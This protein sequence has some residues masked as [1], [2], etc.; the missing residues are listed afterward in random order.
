MTGEE[1]G[2]WIQGASVVVAVGASVV[3]LVVGAVDRR[4]AKGNAEKDREAARS[5][6]AEERLAAAQHARRVADFEALLRLAENQRRGGS[7][8]G[9]TR[10]ALGAEA[11]VLTAMIGPERLPH[12]S[13][14]LNP[15]SETELRAFMEAPDTVEWQKRATEAHLALLQ[16]AR[17]IRDASDGRALRS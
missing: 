17:E 9:E 5:L 8:D 2:L 11:A 3:A 16:L 15:E 14:E 4:A 7:S 6:A 1:V 10:R 12:L 13:S